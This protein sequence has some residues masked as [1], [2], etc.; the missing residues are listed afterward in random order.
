[1][2][3]ITLIISVSFFG[4]LLLTEQIAPLR[5]RK[6]PFLQRFLLNMVLT[7]VVF[8]VG[9]LAVRNAALLTS[10]WSVSHSFGIVMLVPLPAWGRVVVGILMMDLT[11]YYWHWANHRIPLLWR[12]HNVHHL[13]PDMDV[14]TSFRF[15]FVEILYSTAFR[16]LQVVVLG[17]APL[18]YVVYETIFACC[19]MFHHSNLRLP[20]QLERLLN[21]V[22]V[23][24]RMH[25]IHHSVVKGET[26]SNYSVV[27]R[28]WD[29]LHR[30]L[31][32]NIRQSTINIGVPGYQE[33][34]D[35]RL[36]TLM[37]MPFVKQKEYWK[38]ADGSPIG[39][40]QVVNVKATTLLE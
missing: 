30:T 4:M 1:M 2:K 22:I 39:S 33:P 7:A 27:F 11:F 37:K 23:T 32:L 20:L 5:S 25:G 29:W 12:F 8:L 19:T 14:S 10:K 13:D 40:N 31:V 26:N 36:L 35:N 38:L 9:S 24:P 21:K 15:H 34:E 3:Y 17:I 18:T 6:Q 16:I 28:C